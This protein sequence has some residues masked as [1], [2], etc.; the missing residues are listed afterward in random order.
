MIFRPIYRPISIFENFELT[1]ENFE[2][3]KISI[4]SYSGCK[5]RMDMSDSALNTLDIIFPFFRSLVPLCYHLDDLRTHEITKKSYFSQ[6]ANE[7]SMLPM[8]PKMVLKNFEIST[9]P[10]SRS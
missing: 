2:I 7:T 8:V 9:I 5:S 6:P 4:C 3:F 1:N 10:K